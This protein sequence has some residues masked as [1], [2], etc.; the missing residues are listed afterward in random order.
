MCRPEIEMD[1]LVWC[2]TV[3]SAVEGTVGRHEAQ[4]LVSHSQPERIRLTDPEGFLLENDIV[5]DI[6]AAVSHDGVLQ[7]GTLE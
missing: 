2:R 1:V 6:F 7:A 5:S 3:R 4:G